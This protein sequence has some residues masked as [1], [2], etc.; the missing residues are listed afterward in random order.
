[1]YFQKRLDLYQVL[2]SLEQRRFTT[3]VITKETRQEKTKDLPKLSFD[4]QKLKN[5]VATIIKERV[6]KLEPIV[7]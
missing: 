6:P 3:K 7:K 5:Y 2:F 1:M 4:K